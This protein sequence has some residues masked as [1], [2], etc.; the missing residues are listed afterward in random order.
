MPTSVQLWRAL[1]DET[2]LRVLN[3][4][5]RGELCVCEITRILEIGQ[6]KA[7]RHLAR[8]RNAGLVID[9]REGAWMYYSLAPPEGLTHRWVLEWLAEAQSE[10]PR[11]GA[12]LETLDTLQKRG[13]L[14]VQCAGD[15]QRQTPAVAVAARP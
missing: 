13:E 2:R 9:R 5:S 6:S 8:L 12:D 15:G 3:L 1:A 7:S 14:C 4:L 10:I 11:A